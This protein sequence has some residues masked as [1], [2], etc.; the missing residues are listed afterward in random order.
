[1][2]ADLE[3]GI[4]DVDLLQLGLLQAQDVD[5]VFRYQVG[6]GLGGVPEDG[7]EAGN[8]PAAYF[9]G[10]ASALLRGSAPIPELGD[11]S[12]FGLALMIG[13]GLL[14]FL[15]LGLGIGRR[16]LGSIGLIGLRGARLA[17]AG[18]HGNGGC[19]FGAGRGKMMR[20]QPLDELRLSTADLQAKISQSILKF[21]HTQ[22]AEVLPFAT[23][24][25]GGVV[26][27][28]RCAGRPPVCGESTC[29]CMCRRCAG[30]RSDRERAVSTCRSQGE[31]AGVSKC[32]C[33]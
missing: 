2:A 10:V 20:L 12:P 4:V 5:A 23:C 15:G 22:G 8:V 14:R 13:G 1:M 7:A 28:R 21:W 25:A 26:G 29:S 24:S 19:C 33:W 32:R 11:G 3:L 30:K 31:C 17:L 9:E 27:G 6:E 18:G 16:P